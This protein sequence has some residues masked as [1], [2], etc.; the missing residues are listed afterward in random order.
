MCLLLK[1]AVGYIGS[2]QE[3][4]LAIMYMKYVHTVRPL[5][6]YNTM[7]V[8]ACIAAKIIQVHTRV[9]GPTCLFV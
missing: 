7:F 4:N 1:Y 2:T 9:L 5:I 6:T 3:M 8:H